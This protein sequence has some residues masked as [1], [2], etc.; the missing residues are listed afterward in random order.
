MLGLFA[1]LDPDTEDTAI[2]LAASQNKTHYHNYHRTF[3]EDAFMSP[4]D[5]DRHKIR[6]II[7]PPPKS[8][9]EHGY[10]PPLPGRLY[11][12]AQC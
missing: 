1:L 10:S 8:I 3:Y 2:G 9:I 12:S 7:G 4:L 5:L 11:P 6:V